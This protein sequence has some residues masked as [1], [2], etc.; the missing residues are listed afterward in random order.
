MKYIIAICLLI[1]SVTIFARNENLD[2]ICSFG[3]DITKISSTLHSQTSFVE[4]WFEDDYFLFLAYSLKDKKTRGFAIGDFKTN[5][6]IFQFEIDNDN[7]S[8]RSIS[9]RLDIKQY[10]ELIDTFQT[11][12][13][14]ITSHLRG[15]F[16]IDYINGDSRWNY[17]SYT[18]KTL[19]PVKR[20]EFLSYER[21]YSNYINTNSFPNI[22]EKLTFYGIILA[23]APFLQEE[24]QY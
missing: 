8:Y 23:T 1:N 10:I 13:P 9:R 21:D 6:K 16:Y 12:I 3:S 7:I 22:V 20:Y 15:G 4:E 18:I 5:R 14:N 19:T 11:S 2:S 17:L 24:P